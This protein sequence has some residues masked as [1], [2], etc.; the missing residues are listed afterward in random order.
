MNVATVVPQLDTDFFDER[1]LPKTCSLPPVQQQTGS[2]NIL[3]RVQPPSN[4]IHISEDGVEI[5]QNNS[6]SVSGSPPA[7][8]PPSDFSQIE[9]PSTEA[10]SQSQV[11]I[12]SISDMLHMRANSNYSKEASY[13]DLPLKSI[14]I[15]TSHEEMREN[16]DLNLSAKPPTTTRDSKVANKSHIFYSREIFFRNQN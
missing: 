8:V 1:G 10:T 4:A 16:R 13:T 6:T 11:D 2:M 3:K 9:F 15:W 12:S 14:G 5:Q 7:S